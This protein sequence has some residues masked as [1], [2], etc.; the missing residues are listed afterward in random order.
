MENLYSLITD[1]ASEDTKNALQ[2]SFTSLKISIGNYLN[3]LEQVESSLSRQT[4]LINSTP[5]NRFSIEQSN[6][7]KVLEIVKEQIYSN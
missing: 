5:N 4:A 3:K 1:T 2:N 7:A 6:R